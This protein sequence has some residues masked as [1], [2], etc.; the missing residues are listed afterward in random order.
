MP[1][2]HE[3][4]FFEMFLRNLI[5]VPANELKTLGITHFIFSSR[6]PMPF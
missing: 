3:R 4:I 1:K 2:L 5:Y 6:K